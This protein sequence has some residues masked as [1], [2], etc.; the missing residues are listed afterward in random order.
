LGMRQSLV[1]PPLLVSVP[2][3]VDRVAVMR[4]GG[5]LRCT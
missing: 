3:V 2:V 4:R 1:S 5:G